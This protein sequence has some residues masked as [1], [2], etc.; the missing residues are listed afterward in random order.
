MQ[1]RKFGRT[2]LTVSRL[3]LGTMT[4]GLQTEEDVSRRILDTAADAGVNFIDTADVY[5]LGAG[6]SNAGRTEEIV[7][8]W[9][10]GKRDRFILAT[11]AVGKMGPSAWDQGASRKHLLDAIDAS[12]RRL[13]TDYVDLYQ[14]HSDD[15]NTPLDETLEALDAIVRSGKARYIGVS[16]FLAYRL[17]RAL[18]RADV[19]R[20]ARFVSVQPRYNLLF[21]QIERELL[22]LA[23]EEQLA[24]IPY[25]P[26]AGGLLTGKHRV[27]AAPTSGRFTETV[28]KAGAVYQERYWHQ[29]EFETIEKLKAIATPTGES[30]TRISLAWVLANPLITSA[31]I[32]ASSAEQ[33]SDTLSTS[34]LVLDAQVKTQ[35]DEVSHEYRWGDAA[36]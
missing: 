36:R 21:R 7:G 2:G 22:P 19:L 15:A 16:N 35:L 13:G 17:A 28:G 1:Y 3:C 32:G 20:V 4:F 5:P 25:N 31:I 33:L 29:R 12:L 26:L 14:L 34:E 30:L 24:V 8:R 10:K 18:G 23:D 6:E 11:K 9:L 27:D